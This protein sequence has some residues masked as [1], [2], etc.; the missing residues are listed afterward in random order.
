MW[1]SSGFCRSIS[2]SLICG[3][4]VTS[5]CTCSFLAFGA[6]AAACWELLAHPSS[7]IRSSQGSTG[8]VCRDGNG[9]NDGD[10]AFN[11]GGNHSTAL[12]AL[13]ATRPGVTTALSNTMLMRAIAAA[14]ATVLAGTG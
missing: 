1:R 3:P 14:F 9:D 6:M 2:P 4:R 7:A 13:T 5:A 11:D 8:Q 12:L 10:G